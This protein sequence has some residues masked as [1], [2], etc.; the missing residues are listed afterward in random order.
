MTDLKTCIG[1]ILRHKHRKG[2]DIAEY[3]KNL[4]N[5]AKSDA[6]AILAQK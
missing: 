6:I 2:S 4:I 1:I 3:I 5:I